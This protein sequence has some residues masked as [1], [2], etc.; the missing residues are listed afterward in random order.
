MNP[1]PWRSLKT[2]D[3]V[4]L[5]MVEPSALAELENGLDEDLSQPKQFFDSDPMELVS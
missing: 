5:D 2:S 4:L 1:H 3:M